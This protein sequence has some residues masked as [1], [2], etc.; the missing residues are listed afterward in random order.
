MKNLI[1]SITILT[2]MVI[3]GFTEPFRDSRETDH[4]DT[5]QD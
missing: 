3:G 2:L 4:S 1:E 5:T